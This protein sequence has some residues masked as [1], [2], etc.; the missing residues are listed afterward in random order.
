[1]IFS[2]LFW[3]EYFLKK[4]I[5]YVDYMCMSFLELLWL[6]I[7]TWKVLDELMF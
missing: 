6:I 2:E 5:V 1:M 3:L 7:V 4:Q